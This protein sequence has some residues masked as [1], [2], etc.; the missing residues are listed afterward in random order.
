MNLTCP[1]YPDDVITAPEGS[2]IQVK[3]C[4]EGLNDDNDSYRFK[5]LILKNVT[6]NG[7][8]VDYDI[9]CDVN[10]NYMEKTFVS[11]YHPKCSS[12]SGTST[13]VLTMYVYRHN[14]GQWIYLETYRSGIF[15]DT[16]KMLL[17]NITSKYKSAFF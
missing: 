13:L 9:L 5:L 2:L 14:N 4:F 7:K 8:F 6:E 16:T 10:Y 15:T 11:S 1:T 17:L 12:A 3:F